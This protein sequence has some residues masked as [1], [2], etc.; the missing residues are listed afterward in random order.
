MS[1]SYFFIFDHILYYYKKNLFLFF[2]Y[3]FWRKKKLRKFFEIYLKVLGSYSVEVLSNCLHDF[4]QDKPSFQISLLTTSS[5]QISNETPAST[6]TTTTT[7][8]RNSINNLDLIY[9]FLQVKDDVEQQ[10]LKLSSQS[11]KALAVAKCLQIEFHSMHKNF[12]IF[13]YAKAVVF[14]DLVVAQVV[15]TFQIEKSLNPFMQVIE[16]NLS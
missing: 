8:H 15:S 5:S 1:F 10:K 13:L 11:Q 4:S 16:I 2:R 7:T 14:Y 9:S 3:Y 12:L 6:T